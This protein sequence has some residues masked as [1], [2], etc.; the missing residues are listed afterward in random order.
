LKPV[1][2]YEDDEVSI[3]VRPINFEGYNNAIENK[4]LIKEHSKKYY[5]DNRETI[6]EK[7]KKWRVE[8]PEAYNKY[9]QDNKEKCIKKAK[10]WNDEHP[11][12]YK[13]IKKKYNKKHYQDNKEYY[14]DKVKKWRAENPEAYRTQYKE[15]YEK[16]KL[17]KLEASKDNL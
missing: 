8:N 15:Q 12:A 14:I 16:M 1:Y 5:Q 9:Y 10:K 2:T 3:V 6:C 17:K 4:W 13:I 11:E 7:S